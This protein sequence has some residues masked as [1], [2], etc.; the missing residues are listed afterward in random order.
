MEEK[1]DKK[2]V[3]A[4][5]RGLNIL[6]ILSSDLSG[7]G[8]PLAEIAKRMDLKR[9]TAHNLL[10]TLCLCGYAE[11]SGAGYYHVGWKLQRLSRERNLRNFSRDLALNSL[12]ALAKNT[13]ESLVYAVLVNNRRHVVARASGG[14]DVQVDI[15]QLEP[16]HPCFWRTVTGRILAAYCLPQE[17]EQ[18]VANQGF[19]EKSWQGI[20]S[21]EALLGQLDKIRGQGW[22]SDLSGEVFS[23]A[24]PVLGSKNLLL[25][26]IGI[27]MPMFRRVP[28]RDQELISLLQEAAGELAKELLASASRPNL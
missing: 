10:K 15:T 11:N 21:L 27:H 9:T 13:G 20:F 28:E 14:Q 1:Q 22:V 17:L 5:H 18:I 25:G 23:A 8:I 3:E 26:T 16:D 19:P 12:G 4:L 7:T 24:V 2:P 6:E